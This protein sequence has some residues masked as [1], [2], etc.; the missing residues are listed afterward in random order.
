MPILDPN[1]PVQIDQPDGDTVYLPPWGY[2]VSHMKDL[3][4]PV[5]ITLRGINESLE[6]IDNKL[7]DWIE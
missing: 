1:T 3:V 7:S 5:T 2:I 4:D 6:V